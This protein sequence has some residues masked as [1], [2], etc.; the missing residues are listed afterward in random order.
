VPVDN[1]KALLAGEEKRFDL[2]VEGLMGEVRA[3]GTELRCHAGLDNLQISAKNR[4][5]KANCDSPI[6]HLFLLPLVT[7]RAPLA[8]VRDALRMW[9]HL[10]Q[11]K[12]HA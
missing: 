6:S 4:D 3:E 2:G 8:H 7:D 9:S 11:R 1:D 10:T 12:Q 5:D